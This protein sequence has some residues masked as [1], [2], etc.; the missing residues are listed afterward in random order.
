VKYRAIRG[1]LYKGTRYKPG[2]TFEAEQGDVQSLIDSGI[3]AEEQPVY[4]PPARTTTRPL[5]RP[6]EPERE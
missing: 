3:I 5:A 4:V 1:V 2:D 6:I